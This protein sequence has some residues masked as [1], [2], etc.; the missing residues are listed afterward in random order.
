MK[1]LVVEVTLSRRGRW[2]D[3]L[4]WCDGVLCPP[5][6]TDGGGRGHNHGAGDGSEAQQQVRA[7]GEGQLRRE[8]RGAGSHQRENK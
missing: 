4:W 2:P 8:P 3:V 1:L 7:D 6:V 5:R